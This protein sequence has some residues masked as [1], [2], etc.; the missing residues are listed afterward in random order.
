MDQLFIATTNIHKLNEFRL[1]LRDFAIQLR[2][3]EELP[4][5]IPE[6]E[7]TGKTLAENACLKATCWAKATLSWTLADDTGLEVKAL[8]GAPGVHTSRFAG[9]K[10]SGSDNR[11]KLLRELEGVGPQ[12]REATF[13]CSLA[14]ASPKGDVVFEARGECA[15]L[16]LEQ[17][18]GS[19][20]FGYDSLFYIPT[21]QKTLAEMTPNE[22]AKYSHRAHAIAKLKACLKTDTFS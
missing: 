3:L 22:L 21:A 15:G 9:P 11:A 4:D 19:S 20:G 6:V 18:A 14:L 10:A 2:S 8:A 13:V 5:T 17:P 12:Q 1:L 7:E 16:I